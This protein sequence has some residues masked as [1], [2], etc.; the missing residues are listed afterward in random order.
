[1]LNE[2]FFSSLSAK[3]FITDEVDHVD[4]DDDN[5]HVDDSDIH[6]DYDDDDYGKAELRNGWVISYTKCANFWNWSTL[7]P[8]KVKFV[9]TKYTW[10]NFSSL[11]YG[12]L[13]IISYKAANSPIQIY[14]L[15]CMVLTHSYLI[16]V[17][18]FTWAKFLENKIYTEKRQ[19][20]A[21]NL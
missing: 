5:D 4:N 13:F 20:L 3:I 10:G 1:M 11:W 18:F 17:I 19:F 15:I 8:I 14:M 16:F 2:Y 21:L 6:N 12:A 7:R 9:K